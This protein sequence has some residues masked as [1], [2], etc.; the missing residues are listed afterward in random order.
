M[1]ECWPFFERRTELRMLDHRGSLQVAAVDHDRGC[2]TAD[3]G[4]TRPLKPRR[5]SCG[6]P[7]DAP[8][9]FPLPSPAPAYSTPRGG[10]DHR[11]RCCDW[12]VIRAAM[13]LIKATKD[14]ESGA[15]TSKVRR[16]GFVG[17][18][19]PG[20]ATPTGHRKWAPQSASSQMMAMMLL[21]TT[22]R[23]TAR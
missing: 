13:P 16:L 9:G 1:H 21:T 17:T 4:A 5:A 23:T 3:S 12:L 19:P 14:L 18:S 8:W 6:V 22:T 11:P 10:G 2:P 15:S 20:R 7:D